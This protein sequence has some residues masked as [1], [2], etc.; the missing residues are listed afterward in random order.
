MRSAKASAVAALV[1]VLLLAPQ[2]VFA[3]VTGTLP[4][5][6]L[7]LVVGLSVVVTTGLATQ[8]WPSPTGSIRT[9]S[10]MS[11]WPAVLSAIAGRRLLAVCSAV[12]AVLLLV[13]A[14]TAEPDG[15]T[16]RRSW[17]GFSGDTDRYPGWLYTVPIGLL[18]L[19]LLAA[20]WWALRQIEAQPGRAGDQQDLVLRARTGARAVRGALFGIAGSAAWIGI[21]MG[22]A[23]NQATQKMRVA[24]SVAAA[25]P[26]YPRAPHD[27]VQ[28]A[29]MATIVL[30][31]CLGLIAVLAVGGLPE[32]RLTGRRLRHDEDRA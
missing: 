28:D 11:R 24:V 13:G 23:I 7:P 5:A 25:D 30:G 12:L 4:G 2:S 19:A 1:A 16:F 15:E 18:A 3:S 27:V 26:T 9:A 32:P 8:L 17:Q 6:S 21:I 29:G 14:V 10:L 22:A 31:A 20:T